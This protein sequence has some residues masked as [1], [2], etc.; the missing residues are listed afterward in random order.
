MD[1]QVWDFLKHLEPETCKRRPAHPLWSVPIIKNAIQHWLCQGLGG[2]TPLLLQLKPYLDMVKRFDANLRSKRIPVRQQ[3]L[4]QDDTS[5]HTANTALELLAGVFQ[6]WVL[7]RR[8]EVE[9]APRS[10]YINMLDFYLWVYLKVVVYRGKLTTLHELKVA[11][12]TEIARVPTETCKVAIHNFKWRTKKSLD[13]KGGHIE[14]HFIK[15]S[16]N[17]FWNVTIHFF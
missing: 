15:S 16:I 13:L 12:E 3:W 8:T 1:T 14:H 2:T 5:S 4:M 6:E 9:W 17:W 7:S 10:P 11:I